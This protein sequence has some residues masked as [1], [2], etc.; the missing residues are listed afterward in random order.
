MPPRRTG[1]AAKAEAL[2]TFVV[3]FD[4]DV[5]GTLR[6]DVEAPSARAA[7]LEFLRRCRA[8]GFVHRDAGASLLVTS[9]ADRLE[10]WTAHNAYRV[11]FHSCLRAGDGR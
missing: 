10:R 6:E 11:A 5:D 8:D 3:E 4:W 7:S 1:R 2:D 9:S